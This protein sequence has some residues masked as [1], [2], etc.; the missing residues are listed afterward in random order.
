LIVSEGFLMSHGGRY[1]PSARLLAVDHCRDKRESRRAASRFISG[2]YGRVKIMGFDIASLREKR[3]THKFTIE[4]E[5]VEITFRPH[6]VTP[7]LR[8]KW[9][10]QI[11]DDQKD[12][13]NDGAA[14]DY[15]CKLLSNVLIDWNL[16]ADGEP[17]PLTYDNLL[18]LPDTLTVRL[19]RELFEAVGKLA[20]KKSANP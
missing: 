11:Q 15:D 2:D 12:E 3:T 1:L 17:F 14:S 8:A 9:T 10:R 7:E 5:E 20:L 4:G 16:T 6:L 13:S 19:V 18:K